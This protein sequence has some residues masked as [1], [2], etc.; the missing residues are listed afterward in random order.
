MAWGGGRAFAHRWANATAGRVVAGVLV[1]AV[2]LNRIWETAYGSHTPFDLKHLHA[3][4]VAGAHEWWRALSDLV[5]KFGYVDV[6]LP[7]IVPLVWFA[8][9]AALFVSAFAACTR[10]ERGL[11][12][13]V[14]GAALL[15]PI[16]FYAVIIRPTGFGLQG[17]HLLPLL[18]AVP[19]L[20]G[21]ACYRHR[22][23]AAAAF[24]N[25]LA[26]AVPVAVAIMQAI[27]WYV[28]ARRYAV[29]GSGP[30]WFLGSAAWTPPAGWWTW[31]TATVVGCLCLVA[32]ATRQLRAPTPPAP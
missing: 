30:T 19:L 28:N 6:Q 20:A 26:P 13:V 5:G 4:L 27:A 2:A 31:L 15:G 1:A 12:I 16:A 17:R 23:R 21:E 7:L 14:L 22:D 24:V 3:G 25:A 9:V 11:L 32:L 29:S 18:V 10:R 8:L